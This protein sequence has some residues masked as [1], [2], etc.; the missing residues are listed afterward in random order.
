MSHKPY[1]RMKK[2][3]VAPHAGVHSWNVADICAKYGL[4]KNSM[5][6]GGVIGI[7]ELGGGYA[8]SDLDSFSQ[9][10]GLPK[11]KVIDVNIDGASNSPGG[12]ADGE[13]AL[14]IQVAVATYYYLTGKM[15]VVK[16]LW[17][18]NTTD[19][20]AV[21]ATR[22]VVE[23]CS[24]LSI[25]WGSSEQNWGPQAIATFDAA[26]KAATEAGLS[27]TCA[28]GDNSAD[29]SIGT[30]TVDFPSASQYVIGCGGT[31]KT[32]TGET[33][34]GDGNQDDGGT[35]GGF[36]AFV[37]RPSWQTGINPQYGNTSGRMVPDVAGNA[38]PNTAWNI[39]L[40]GQYQS[41]GGTSAVAPFYA[42]LI[43]AAGPKHGNL[44]PVFW[45]N[46]GVFV[47]ITKG[48]NGYSASAGPDPATGLGVPTQAMLALI[49][50]GSTPDPVKP[51]T[52]PVKPP[53]DPPAPPVYPRSV[54]INGSLSIDPSGNVVS[55]VAPSAQIRAISDM[56]GSVLGKLKTLVDEASAL[57]ATYAPYA[58]AFLDAA[59]NFA[60]SPN[61]VT[62]IK[63]WGAVRSFQ[64]TVPHAIALHHAVNVSGILQIVEAGLQAF[65]QIWSLTHGG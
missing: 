53:V 61:E 21:A 18:A 14:D 2:P 60:D 49:S 32:D 31:A 10:N 52:D 29:D 20:F 64:N 59:K 62:F 51:P 54:K 65:L 55:F 39:V 42:G 45:A 48:S 9:L 33:A 40:Y 34:W 7:I 56:F 1:F 5:P 11:I 8:Q 30:P 35:G 36:S 13:V 22:A 58:Q 27:I 15:P 4:T 37:S 24:V 57:S 3:G 63:L 50:K 26:A 43:A 17:M 6:G 16:V 28:S 38:D 46:P 41:I 23:D 47:D 19:A 12:D 25:S 44:N